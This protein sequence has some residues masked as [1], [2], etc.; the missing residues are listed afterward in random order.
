MN[1]ANLQI[2]GLLMAVASINEVLVQKGFLTRDEVDE[3]L[4]QAGVSLAG[5]GRLYADMSPANRSAVC[6]PIRFLQSA[7]HAQD[8][9]SVPSF[10]NVARAVGQTS[11]P[12][13]EPA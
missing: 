2:E 9:T 12:Y 3:A 10:Y 5:E 4:Q 6:F 13:G 8:R 11:A 7:N 1:V